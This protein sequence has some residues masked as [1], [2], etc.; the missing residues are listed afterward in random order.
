MEPAITAGIAGLL[1]FLSPCILPLVP[2]Y[3]AVLAGGAGGEGKPRNAALGRALLFVLG[4]SFVFVLLGLGASVVGGY[5]RA[6][7]PFLERMGGVIVILLGLHQLGLLK[8]VPLYRERRLN[9]PPGGSPWAA[10]VIGVVFAFG[11]TPCVGPV[12]AGILTLAGT[13]GRAAYGAGLLGAY[14]AGL[15]L[16]FIIAALGYQ[17]LLRVLR[18][19]GRF[20]RYFELAGGALLV[21]LGLLLA[22]GKLWLLNRIGQ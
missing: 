8:L 10:F 12:L 6:Y 20:T 16:P 17:S 4:F 18:S 13:A 9:M 19:L 5:L 7:Q 1:S 21:I 3:L 22:S 15:G 14:S 2:A 11:W